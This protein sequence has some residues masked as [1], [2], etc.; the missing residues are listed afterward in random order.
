[1]AVKKWIEGVDY[2]VLK[3][4][5][6]VQHDAYTRGFRRAQLGVSFVQFYRR[7]SRLAALLE[8]G[9]AAGKQQLR[10]RANKGY[11]KTSNL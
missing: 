10:L 3:D 4:G 5:A 8:A 9:W 11:G 6:V 2:E 7:G 1:M